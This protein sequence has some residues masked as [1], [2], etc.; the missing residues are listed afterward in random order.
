MKKKIENNIKIFIWFFDIIFIGAVSGFGL[1]SIY[2]TLNFFPLFFSIFIGL[3]WGCVV[4]FLFTWFYFCLKLR[5]K[6]K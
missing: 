3:L 6:E 4:T 1:Y 2:N 5:E